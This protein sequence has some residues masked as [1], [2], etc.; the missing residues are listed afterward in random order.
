MPYPWLDEF[1]AAEDLPASF[2]AT[3][4]RICAPIAELAEEA[5]QAIGRT[6]VIGL[7]GPQGSGKSTIAA[8]VRE[9]LIRQGRT[10]AVLALDDL[11]LPKEQRARLAAEVHPLFATRGPPGTHDP[12]LGLEILGLLAR[13]GELAMPCFDKAADTRRPPEDWTHVTCPVDVVLFEGWCVGAR[14]Q[15][16]EALDEPVND[17]ER[18][19]DPDGRWRTFV[20]TALD[21]AYRPLFARVDRLVMLAPRGFAV[22]AGW[23]AEQEAKLRARTGRGMGGDEVAR[24]VAHY[25][26]LTRWILEEMPSRADRVFPLASDRHPTRPASTRRIN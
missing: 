5:R 10:A 11:Y 14:P 20:N 9:I 17:L 1:L 6:V 23:R 18:N 25:E 22:V 12:A 24:F 26:R 7:C 19:E 8:A 16:P 3:V 4:E 15:P 21:G 2:R 13:P